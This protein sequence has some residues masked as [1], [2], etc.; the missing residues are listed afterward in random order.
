MNNSTTSDFFVR[1]LDRR[2]FLRLTGLAGGG[3]MLAV[4]FG[5]SRESTETAPADQPDAAPFTP[6]AY[7]Q[8]TE[9]S[10]LIHAPNP[11]V[12]QGV[13]TSM[14]MIVAEELDADWNDVTVVQSDIDDARYG[15]QFAGGSMSVPQNWERL[16]R[17]G[18]VAREMLVAAAALRWEVDPSE[19]ETRDSTVIH[20]QT[21]RSL[22]YF[23]LAETA[24]SLPVPDPASVQLKNIA[25]FR[26]LG[27]RVSGVDNPD[28]VTGRP[29]FGI[30]ASVAG[31]RF[32]AYVRCPVRGGT[33]LSANLDAVRALAGVVD[34]F[35]VEGNGNPA[36]LAAGVAIVAVDTWSAFK[37]RSALQVT[38]D[39]K[40]AVQ[41]SWSNAVEQ[42]RSLAKA[43]GSATVIDTGD[44]EAAFE[45]AAQR[46]EAFYQYAF[47]NHAQL[48]PQNTT[49]WWHDGQ[50][51]LWAPTQTPQA[52]VAGVAK[53]IGV[54]PAQVTLHQRRA[55]GGFGRRLV[56]D[57]VME[58][59]VIAHRVGYPVKLTWTREDDMAFGF[60]R[61]G[62]FHALSGALD[63]GGNVV[64]WKNHFVSFS[65][66][67]EK[68]VAG[69]GLSGKTDPGPFIP[70]YR[71]TQTLLPWQTPCGYW[72]AP[73]SNVIAFAHQSFLHE[74]STAA[75]RDHLDFLL[76]LLGES[77]WLENDN[78]HAL[79]T[80]RAAGVLRR[81][82][83]AA[84]WGR[85]L[86]PGRGLG[87]AFY[88]SHAGHVA[89]VA[90]VS[91][92]PSRQL[93][94][95]RVTVAADVGP[96]VNMSGAENQVQGSVID[97]LSTLLAQRMT[98]E[99]GRA[100]ETNFHQYPLLRMPQAPAV[101]V[102]FIQSDF[103]PSGLGEPALPPLAPAVANAIY[104]ASGIRVRKMPLIEEGFRT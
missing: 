60:Y 67:G 39:E 3:L 51:E 75:G 11:E 68:P 101:D 18:A 58:A 57:V 54:D 56:N 10:I 97:G 31:L 92:S 21:G 26:L 29:L 12:G 70:N 48:E 99:Q 103:P 6:N 30:D 83:E 15:R 37:A 74:L 88:F 28:L 79:H 63:D 84:G 44:V 49:A 27:S 45:N 20:R 86:P 81:A 59:A 7:V 62:G 87:L 8:I 52:A 40:N 1:Q 76:A 32:A 42:A 41:D 93:V 24:A 90:D 95:H 98:F 2:S 82:A 13:K 64:G 9:D 100:L 33:V 89:Q 4:Q 19:C 91:V 71:I 53:L 16:R 85:E 69:G 25:D 80:G 34:A 94:V 102:H 78:P 77:R 96:I 14:P 50:M 46:V 55:G 104:A 38:W 65:A 43:E 36:E 73:G 35:I 47:V 72:R 5:C 66:D 61:A 17:A 22:T 23:E